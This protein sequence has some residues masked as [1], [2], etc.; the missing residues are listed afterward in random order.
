MAIKNHTVLNGER[1]PTPLNQRHPVLYSTVA[2]AGSFRSA[3]TP[4]RDTLVSL[5]AMY[6]RSY[7]MRRQDMFKWG[8]HRLKKTT[9]TLNK[10]PARPNIHFDSYTTI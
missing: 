1:L 8:S 2:A 3:S 10:E 5:A 6:T 4:Y 9:V 7:Q